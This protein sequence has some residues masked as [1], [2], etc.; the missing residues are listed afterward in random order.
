MPRARDCCS[1]AAAA[2]AG[3]K[4]ERSKQARAHGAARSRDAAA[5]RPAGSRAPVHAHAASYQMP[6]AETDENH[7]VL[8]PNFPPRIPF[9]VVYRDRHGRVRYAPPFYGLR[10]RSARELSR[11]VPD[12]SRAGAGRAPGGGC[13]VVFQLVRLRVLRDTPDIHVRTDTVGIEKKLFVCPLHPSVEFT[14]CTK[15]YSRRQS[16]LCIRE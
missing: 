6:H 4:G 7:A 8:L 5:G 16:L 3:E 14:H 10:A 15:K 13:T 9:F 1:L 11:G 2:V 12:G